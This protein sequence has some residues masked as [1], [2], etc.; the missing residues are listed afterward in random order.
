MARMRNIAVLMLLTG[1]LSS[2]CVRSSRGANNQTATNGSGEICHEETPT[3]SSI[4]R[5]VCRT[6]D[7]V[8]DDKRGARDMLS[9]KPTPISPR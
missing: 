8:E 6:P 5:E 3:G 1:A 9:P 2:G 4:S 7:Q